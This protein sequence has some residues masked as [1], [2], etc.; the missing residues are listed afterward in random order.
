MRSNAAPSRRSGR[1]RVVHVPMMDWSPTEGVAR[2]CTALAGALHDVES[3]LVTASDPGSDAHPFSAWH[4]NPGWIPRAVF[5]PA[6]SRLIDA[7]DPDIVHLHGGSIAPA[8]AFAPAFKDRTVVATSLSGVA[9]P[10]RGQLRVGRLVEHVRSNVTL[11]R[12]AAAAA[13]G[14]GISR[15]AL[16]T[17]R[18]A[19]LC[20]PD[21]EVERSFSA[22]GPVVRVNGAA[23]IAPTEARWSAEPVVVFAGRAERARGVDDLIAAFPLVR[24]EIPKARLRLVLLPGPEAAR[25]A[26]ALADV[27]WADVGVGAVADLQAELAACQVAAFPFRWS[28]T[29]TPAL[30][31]AEAMATGLP[32]VATSVSCL[33]PLVEPGRNGYLVAPS[34]PAALATALADALRDPDRWTALS[35]GARQTIDEQWSWAGAAERTRVAYDLALE[36]RRST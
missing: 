7:I 22:S 32:L 11:T 30:A 33:A 31:A 16:R 29:L 10:D 13:G 28:A 23:T 20:T 2:A 15:R 25:W 27:P 14:V 17:G 34:D 24:R 36:R 35:R 6:F 9:L 4:A 3:H 21:D 18:V 12:S 5:R 26:A 8:L 19:V 1:L